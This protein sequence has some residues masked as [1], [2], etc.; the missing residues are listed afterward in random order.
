[1]PRQTSALPISHSV[2]CAMNDGTWT[3]ASGTAEL[4]AAMAVVGSHGRGALDRL[5]TGSVSQQLVRAGRLPVLVSQPKHYEDVV[6][7]SPEAPE[8]PCPACLE[9]RR[10][11]DN[12]RFWCAEHSRA[13]EAPHT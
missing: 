12:Q 13:H 3:A 9:V 2:P 5:V 7:A 6:H 10:A 4:D 1:M 8:P 11:S